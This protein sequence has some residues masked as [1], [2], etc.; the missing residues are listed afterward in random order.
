MMR[1]I[2][3]SSLRLRLVMAAVAALLMI[4]GF[5]QLRH[6]PVDALPEF[7]RPYV[8]IQAEA[9][10]LSAQEVEALVTTPLEADLLN[11]VSWVDEIRS[12]SIPGMSSIVLVFEKGVDIMK[13]RQMVQERLIAIHALPNVSTPPMMLNP[14]SSTSRVMMIGLTSSKMSLID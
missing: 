7:A 10:G 1:W 9:L 13:A 4:F 12:E 6:T 8:E 3:G 14:L 2:V 11:G 5:T